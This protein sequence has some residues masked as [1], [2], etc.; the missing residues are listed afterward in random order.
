MLIIVD[1]NPACNCEANGN[2]YTPVITDN[3]NSFYQRTN[4]SDTPYQIPCPAGLRFDVQSC[5]CNYAD[6]VECPVPQCATDSQQ[7][8]GMNTVS[9]PYL[10]VYMMFSLQIMLHE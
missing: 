1:I 9:R 4:I 7:T 3:C 10:H 6:Q 2:Y 5:V 8:A